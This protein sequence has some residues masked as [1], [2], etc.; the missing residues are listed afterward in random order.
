MSPPLRVLIADDELLARK[1]LSRLLGALPDVEV[2]GEASDGEAVLAAVRAGGVDV[3]LLDIHMP[4]L[5]GLDA[6]ALLPEGRP[7]V[8]LCTAHAE[9]AVEAFEHGAV[10][11]VLKPVEP[12][13]LQKALERTRARIE[14]DARPRDTPAPEKTAPRALARLPIP[15]RQGIVLVDPETISHASLDDEL[16]TVFTT[17]GEFLT[18][19]TLNE[20]A[21]KLPEEL[22][23][24][25]HRR[26]LLNLRHVARLEPLE[27]GGYLARTARGHAVEISRQS[28]RELR[29]M[30]GLRRGAEDEG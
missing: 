19:F 21:E 3:V 13:R 1:R 12:A 15:T 4:G 24:R 2:C 9:H 7:R 16:V 23:H 14:A 29:R 17:Q 28:A 8:I 6:L 18:D 11:Y 26:A 20:L 10:D 27:T 5:S 30:L 22:F 25:V